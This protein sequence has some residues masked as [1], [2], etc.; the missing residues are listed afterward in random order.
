[1]TSDSQT[2]SDTSENEITVPSP[3]SEMGDAFASKVV[4]KARL[5]GKHEYFIPN[6]EKLFVGD[7]ILTRNKKNGVAA[8]N[9]VEDYQ[10]E[11]RKFASEHAYWCHAMVYVGHLH[12]VES[13][14]K[15]FFDGLKLRNGSKISDLVDFTES[16]ELL[17]CRSKQLKSKF[18]DLR[19][20]IGRYALADA[21]ILK[22]KYGTTRVL[23]ELFAKNY[24]KEKLTEEVICS[25]Y[26]LEILARGGE[27]MV[28][29]YEKIGTEPDYCF[30]PADFSASE[31]FEKIPLPKMKLVG[32]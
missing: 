18:W 4:R 11:I 28:E 21:T 14:K 7:V 3:T 19:H 32:F 27:C 29:E 13:V 9:I 22:R 17:I 20:K 30:F 24:R 25:E 16:H 1:M 31:E 2:S 15:R 10:K 23:N 8:S 26:A 6:V 12:V 5:S